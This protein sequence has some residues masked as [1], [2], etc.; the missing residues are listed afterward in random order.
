M[1]MYCVHYGA[2]KLILILMASI[3][4]KARAGE[5]RGRIEMH[6]VESNTMLALI[7]G[8]H[9]GIAGLVLFRFLSVLF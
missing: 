4:K 3:R 8:V 9:D 7:H 2:I 5:F 6:V 1:C